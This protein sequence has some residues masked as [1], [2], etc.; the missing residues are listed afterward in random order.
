MVDIWS[1]IPIDWQEIPLKKLVKRLD[2]GTS[3]V[4]EER[5]AKASEPAVLK[6]SAVTSG[7]FL[8]SESKAISTSLAKTL[9][10]TPIAG[11]ILIN[12]KNTKGLVGSSAYVEKDFPNRFLPDL[13]WQIQIT[14]KEDVCPKWLS[15]AL[16]HPR[17][18]NEIRRRANGTADSM[19]NI[20]KPS[21]LS[22]HVPKPPIPEQRAISSTVSKW[23]EAIKQTT[24]L[25]EAKREFK[26]GLAQGLLTGKRRFPDC[27]TP[28][29]T[30]L[31]GEILSL[32]QRPTPKP[33]QPYDAMGIRSHFKGTFAKQVEDPAKVGM[34]VLYIAKAGDLIVNITFAWE[35]AIAIVPPEHDGRL[36]SHRFPTYRPK[37]EVIAPNY[38]RHLITQERFKYLLS[39]I[40]PGGAGRNRVMSKKDF[41]KIESPLPP[42]EEQQKI[43]ATLDSANDEIALLETKLAALREQKKG[44]MQKLLTGEVRVKI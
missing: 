37:T 16:K 5:S 20:T 7:V 41:L 35:G 30:V 1:S 43:A 27:T 22:V 3:V 34:D 15:Y 26:K 38:L 17:V 10:T 25:I 42:L 8:P 14:S 36:V 28:F 31:F 44:L 24:R 33:M 39:G 23:D 21:L 11:G 9:S 12:R 13:V 2:G 32:V 6:T 40:S 18:L 29:K 19:V 4:T